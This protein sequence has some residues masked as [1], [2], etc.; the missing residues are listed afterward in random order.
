MIK[1]KENTLWYETVQFDRI[2]VYVDYKG[3]DN[4]WS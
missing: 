4:I 1:S 3:N 2:Y